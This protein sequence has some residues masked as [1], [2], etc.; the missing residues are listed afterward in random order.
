VDGFPTAD[1]VGVESTVALEVD[2]GT[3]RGRPQNA[4]G[5]ATVEPDVVQSSLEIF[6]IV[7][8]ELGG[9][10]YE[11]PIAEVPASLDDL[12]PGLFV[13]DT[14]GVQP[15]RILESYECCL[16]GRAK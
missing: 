4:I 13:A 1:A 12:H 11:E 7:A 16:G 6:D 5:A 2:E 8:S 3:Y 9:A 10:Q 15:A 14:A